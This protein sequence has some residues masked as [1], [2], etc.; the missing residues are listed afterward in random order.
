MQLY[1]EGTRICGG[2]LSH[3]TCDKN[4]MYSAP[5]YKRLSEQKQNSRSETCISSIACPGSFSPIMTAVFPTGSVGSFAEINPSDD[6][7]ND[8]LADRR[9]QLFIWVC[10]LPLGTVHDLMYVRHELRSQK[11]GGDILGMLRRLL[12]DVLLIVSR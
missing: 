5:M 8:R 7:F 2:K 1:Q 3:R 4:H 10:A 12:A 6:A 11:L 9:S